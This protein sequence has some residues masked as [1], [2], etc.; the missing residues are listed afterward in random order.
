MFRFRERDWGNVE[1]RCRCEHSE[2]STW[3]FPEL[4]FLV[5]RGK[6]MGR[7]WGFSA[8]VRRK[9]KVALVDIVERRI[10]FV[11]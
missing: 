8:S 5:F 2:R 6:L 4:V 3:P 7:I 10:V 11:I 9:R 1:T